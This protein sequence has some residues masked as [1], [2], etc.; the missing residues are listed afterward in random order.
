MEMQLSFIRRNRGRK[1]LPVLCIA[2]EGA[3]YEVLRPVPT[4]ERKVCA[5]RH[6]AQRNG[7]IVHTELMVA[8]PRGVV[9]E[10][11]VADSAFIYSQHAASVQNLEVLD[12]EHDGSFSPSFYGTSTRHLY[13]RCQNDERR[14]HFRSWKERGHRKQYN[15]H[16]F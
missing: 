13:N 12:E 3:T 6:G 11:P 7:G 4:A 8:T 5:A 1:V 15:K 10:A 16:Q 2:P 14:Q 9:T